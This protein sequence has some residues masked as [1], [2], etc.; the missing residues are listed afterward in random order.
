MTA[1]QPQPLRPSGDGATDR[2]PCWY[3][4]GLFV[5]ARSDARTCSTD[6][7]SRQH[8][9]LK[10]ASVD[11]VPLASERPLGTEED[12]LDYHSEERQQA[13]GRGRLTRQEARAADLRVRCL[14]GEP[15]ET[16]SQWEAVDAMPGG[17][18]RLG[19]DAGAWAALGVELA[20]QRQALAAWLARQT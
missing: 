1:A 11:D 13:T 6:C 3:C 20:E 18:E 19:I 9:A 17:H 4:T 7:R 14:H 12:G 8:R 15:V 10:R 5:P 2:A 16:R